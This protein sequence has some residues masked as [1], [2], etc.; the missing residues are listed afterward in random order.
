MALQ[1]FFAAAP[2]TT[3]VT[4]QDIGPQFPPT[5]S[6]STTGRHNHVTSPDF[7]ITAPL[8]STGAGTAGYFASG[9]EQR[10]ARVIT[11]ASL[12]QLSHLYQSFIAD[13]QIR[14]CPRRPEQGA[15]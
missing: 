14:L 4:L 5:S 12:I 1:A 3:T 6:A 8:N 13:H 7:D 15:A 2:L 10:C 11:T 9:Q